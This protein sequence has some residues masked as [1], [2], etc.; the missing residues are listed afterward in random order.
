MTA[1]DVFMKPHNYGYI[2]VIRQ[3][4]ITSACINQSTATIFINK[5]M[6]NARAESLMSHPLC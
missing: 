1:H 3:Y 4:R 6:R 2:V 5:Y